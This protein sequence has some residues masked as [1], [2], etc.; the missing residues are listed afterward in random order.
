[1]G[2]KTWLFFKGTCHT[3]I[4]KEIQIPIHPAAVVTVFCAPAAAASFLQDPQGRV[5]GLVTAVFQLEEARH[6]EVH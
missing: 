1:M 2:R 3:V 5:F 4:M 6:G